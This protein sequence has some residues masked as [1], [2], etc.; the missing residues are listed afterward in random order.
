MSLESHCN[1]PYCSNSEIPIYFHIVIENLHTPILAA[2]S[3]SFM[4][5]L[6]SEYFSNSETMH[7]ILDHVFITVKFRWH[8]T[9]QLM[10]FVREALK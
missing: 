4:P 9:I 7:L 6:I 3:T 5:V 10:R 1:W 2:N 8:Q